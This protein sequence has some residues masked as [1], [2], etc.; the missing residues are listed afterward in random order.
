MIFGSYNI[1]NAGFFLR[2]KTR[3]IAAYTLLCALVNIILNLYLIPRFYIMGAAYS[4]IISYI[5]LTLILSVKGNKLLRVAW[6]VRE[7]LWSVLI[8]IPMVALLKS[9]HFGSL[10]DLLFL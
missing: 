4:T 2:N 1:T 3:N 9:I 5:L 10:K 8:A 7:M 6:P